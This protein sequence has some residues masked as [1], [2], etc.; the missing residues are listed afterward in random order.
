MTPSLLESAT[1]QFGEWHFATTRPGVGLGLVIEGLSDPPADAPEDYLH[2]I[3]LGPEH[4]AAFFDLVDQEGLVVCKGVPCAHPTYRFVRGRSSRG[5]LSQG[6]YYHHDGCSG[7]TKPRVVEI[8]FPHQLVE[9]NIATAVAPFPETVV[10]MLHELPEALHEKD[11]LGPWRARVAAGEPLTRDE[12]DTLQ[13]LI[14]RTVR[15][16]YSAEDARG[17]FR[18]VDARAGAYVERWS[19]GESRFIANN[20]TRRTMQHRRAYLEAASDG[21]ANGNL[22]KRWPA[23]EL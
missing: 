14:V 10:A 19:W 23:E 9:R 16:A 7:P 1:L 4:R 13:G 12:W 11:G 6:E 20:N 3:L 22:V 8:R 21:R 15:R 17:Y 2:A 18:G 5:R